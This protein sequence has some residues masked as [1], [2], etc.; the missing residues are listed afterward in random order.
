MKQLLVIS[1][2]GGTGKTSLTASL[3]SL[4]DNT[5]LADCDVDAADL[6]L[7]LQPQ[8]KN[9]TDFYGGQIAEIDQTKC[10]Q[11]QQCV[12]R[13][14]FGAIEVE[15]DAL[16][17]SSEIKINPLLCEGCTLCRY[18]C[19]EG[20]IE[21]KKNLSGEWY[22]S[23]TRFGS[24][25][26]A[27]LGIGEENSGKLVTQVLS[28]ARQVGASEEKKLLLVDGPPGIGCP[29][30]SAFSGTDLALIVTEPTVSGLHDLERVI[31]LAAH[32]NVQ[33]VVC[34]NKSDL[35]QE[36][37]EKISS[38]CQKSHIPVIGHIPFDQQITQAICLGMTPMEYFAE[39]D[40]HRQQ[41]ATAIKGIFQ[42]LTILLDQI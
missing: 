28:T 29:V 4:F 31:E 36:I 25:V 11:C 8:I 17:W 32:F 23:E 27:Q 20:A 12:E 13:C 5:I 18:V 38:Y 7:L 41:S 24:L 10:M 21:V 33:S 1:G 37:C 30:I 16:F 6:H 9:R 3:A 42:E 40:N 2:K 39:T 26:H 14:R 19:P 34:I 35:N 22:L 15:L